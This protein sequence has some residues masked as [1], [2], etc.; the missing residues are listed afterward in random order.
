MLFNGRLKIPATRFSIA[1]CIANTTITVQ[2]KNRVRGCAT[3]PAPAGKQ[4]D[5]VQRQRPSENAVGRILESDVS[6][7]GCPAARDVGYSYPTYGLHTGRGRLKTVFQTA[8][9]PL[10]FIAVFSPAWWRI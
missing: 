2:P 7:Q 8:S 4:V 10:R 1:F 5:W 9:V 3:H 6:P